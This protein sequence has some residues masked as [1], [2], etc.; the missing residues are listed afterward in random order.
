MGLGLVEENHG[1]PAHGAAHAAVRG[2]RPRVLVLTYAALAGYMIANYLLGLPM[3]GDADDLLKL[4]EIRSFLAHG[5][6]FDRTLPDILQPEPYVSHWPW[7]TDLPYA[8]LAWPLAPLVGDERALA[9]AAFTVPLLLLAPA[10]LC[11][12]RLLAAVGLLDRTVALPLAVLVALPGFLEFAP[13][14]IDYHNLQILLLLASLLLLLQEGRRTAFANG[15]AVALA[16]AISPEFAV[17]HILLMGVYAF[18]FV[19]GRAGGAGRMAS[20]GGGLALAAAVLFVG[21]VPPAEY[22]LARCD[23]YSAPFALALFLAGTA[24][25]T[26]PPLVSQGG[27]AAR[28]GVLGLAAGAALVAVC[29]LFPDCLGGPY[30]ALDPESRAYLLA[31]IGQE[32]SLF[33]RGDVVLSGN[34]PLLTIL[35]TG[36]LAPA[37]LSL[38]AS[39]RNRPIVVLALF[40]VLA[41]VQ[42][43]AYSRYLRYAPFF[44]GI[45]LALTLAAILPPHLAQRF[46]LGCVVPA[47]PLRWFLLAPGLALSLFLTG[48]HLLMRPVTA[49]PTALDI[50]VAG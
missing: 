28:V 1:P 41:I 50:A 20:F 24:F 15:L 26:V 11:Y 3:H 42:A 23:T 14:R 18:D 38:V 31:G 30:A 10:L 6:I 37:A 8:L 19:W 34:L 33:Q 12:D 43:A 25:V 16:T 9:I 13:G 47:G 17:F 22:G 7:I 49:M 32:K 36:A 4:H 21:I 45:G 44:S 2:F 48:Y 39:R 35:F 5:A 40:S 29:A 46:R 27:S